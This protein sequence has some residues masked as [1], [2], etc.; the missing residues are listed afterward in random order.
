M[1]NSLLKR[2]VAIREKCIRIAVGSRLT[3]SFRRLDNDAK[4][5]HGARLVDG[6]WYCTQHPEARLRSRDA[7]IHYL[8]IG[9][10]RRWNPNPFFDSAWYLARN[11]DVTATN[12][13]PAVHYAKEGWREGRQPG[14]EFCLGTYLEL[15]PDVREAGREPLAHYLWCGI[16]EDRKRHPPFGVS[17]QS[18][19]PTPFSK[20]PQDFTDWP[21]PDVRLLAFY[22]PQY[23][24]IPENDAWWG[25]GFTE[26]TNVRRGTPQ[27]EGHHQPHVPHTD[28]GYYDLS[29]P[30]VME[31]QATMARSFGIQG[32]CFYHYWFAGRRLLEMPVDRLLATGRPDFPFCLCWANE[33]WTRRWDGMDSEILIAQEHRPEDDEQFIRDIIPALQDRRY[34]RVGGRPLLL[35]YRPLLLKEPAFVFRRWREICRE[36]GVGEI[37]LAGVLG[38]AFDDPRPVGLD[39][40][41][42]FPPNSTG[43]RPLKMGLAE[44]NPQFRGTFCDYVETRQSAL[45][46]NVSDFRVFRTVI[47]AWDN[48]ARRRDAGV[49]FVNSSPSHYFSWLRFAAEQT[50]RTHGGDERIVFVNALN[51]WAEGCHLEPDAKH[52]YQWLNAT[53]QALLPASSD[54]IA[55]VLVI[56]HDAENF[57]AQNLLLSLLREWKRTRPFPFCLILN[58]SGPL[59][60][61]FEECCPTLVLA[62]CPDPAKRKIAVGVFLPV[63]PRIIYSNTVVNGLL[64]K[65][66]HR[67]G[68]PVLTAAHELQKSIERWAPGPIFEATLEYSDHFIAGSPPVAANL[69]DRHRVPSAA[70]TVEH[71]FIDAD[72]AA[73]D[74]ASVVQIRENLGASPQDILVFGCGTT[75]W[76]KGPDL[77]VE[78]AAACKE[79]GRLRFMW[80]GA[81]S[82]EEQTALDAEVARHG[83]SGRVRFLGL[84]PDVRRFFAAGDIFLL[85]SREDPFPLVALLASDAGLPVVCFAD[86]GGI[87]EFV[88]SEC[89]FVVPFADTAAAGA[90]ILRL[91]SDPGLRERLGSQARE[92]VRREHMTH[93]AAARIA[94]L[95]NGLSRREN[96]VQPSP[97]A[98]PLVSVIVPNYNHAPFLAR[99]LQSIVAQGVEDMEIILLDD[100]ST[101]ASRKVLTAF[102]SA[103]PQARL[104]FN[105]TNSGSTFKQWRKGL[106]M[107]RGQFVWIAESDDCAEPGLLSA[108]LHKMQRHPDTALAYAQSQMIDESD[109]DLGLPLEWT[110]ELSVTRWLEDFSGPGRE[111]IRQVLAIK[112]SIPNASAVLIRNFNGIADLVDDTMRLCADWLLWVRL[113]RRGGIAF[114]ARPL[115]RWRQRT[116]NARTRPPGELEWQEGARVV[117]E[118]AEAIGA[119][120][121]ERE[122]LL[123]AFRTR[124]DGWLKAA[125]GT[126]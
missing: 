9:V 19:A 55:P 3:G 30:E 123:A 72:P 121:Q 36:Q 31:R 110:S 87:P 48:T 119:S 24:R 1:G 61:S 69:R 50:R 26:W 101:D 115:N 92:K 106:R 100:A 20:E 125:G 108:L 22:L 111:E 117:E 13:N 5:L 86:A 11:P 60:S 25:E 2:C 43:F 7:L 39:S 81:G 113:C 104:V 96:C 99:R 95:V 16:R 75:D 80:I 71:S 67:F 29:D 8:R 35:I 85:S 73:Q 118:C 56:G 107:A 76:R 6:T 64:L 28:V 78:I 51:E 94:K 93:V 126:L 66:L 52:G 42:E 102:A 62:D 103:H 68:V 45:E 4:V 49:I 47:P 44:L 18:D 84:Q 17:D 53:R 74:P 70:I 12:Q 57:G 37:H 14:P 46:R 34:I 89:G 21:E 91:A 114:D 124:C 105:E 38:G 54:L 112:N 82:A 63:Q 59:R 40:A 32:F 23:H 27:A 58:G 90:A 109:R 65:E 122:E 88:G 77:F 15:N 116:S 10:H 98:R 97:N 41:V 83:L 33:N 79:D 120:A